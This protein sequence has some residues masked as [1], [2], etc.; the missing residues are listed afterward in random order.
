MHVIKDIHH[1][2][3][4][5]SATIRDAAN[6]IQNTL[7]RI[8]LICNEQGK[9]LGTVTDGD[10]RRSVL[11]SLLS[12]TPVV[13]IMN[14]Y[15]KLLDAT[16]T[17]IDQIYFQMKEFEIDYLP[18]VDSKGRV[19]KVYYYSH[20]EDPIILEN[21]V[22]LVA[23]GIGKRLRPFTKKI[24]KPLIEIGGKPVIMRILESLRHQGF[25]KFYISINYLGHMIR[26][27]LGDGE[28][29]GVSII[30]LKEKKPLGTAGCLSLMREVKNPILVI[31]SDL[32]TDENFCRILTGFKESSAIASVGVRSYSHQIPFGC[33]EKN[34]NRLVSIVEKPTYQYLINAGTYIISPKVLPFVPSNTFLNMTDLLTRLI[35]EEKEV[36]VFYMYE[37]WIDIGQIEDLNYARSL[38]QENEESLIV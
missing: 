25:R 29:F 17:D 5:P 1:I 31:N 24:P 34:K 27:F 6:V 22:L 15:P 14:P 11:R 3:L 36:N 10:I 9:L 13:D 21:P 32:I 12:H 28:K 18:M 8:V 35:E 26:N 33:I 20:F 7:F 23:G 38:Y 16:S 30:Y 4:T 37:K 2:T 19:T